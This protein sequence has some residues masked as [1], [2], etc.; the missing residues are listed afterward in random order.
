MT[1]PHDHTDNTIKLRKPADVLAAVPYLLGFHPTDSI[2]LVGLEGTYVRVVIRL[3]LPPSSADTPQIA[4]R[5]VR[6]LTANRMS[7]ALLIGY[8][9]GCQITPIMDGIST[10]MTGAGIEIMEMLR[11]QDGRYWSYTCHDPQC[12]PLDGTPYDQVS[13]EAAAVAVVSGLVAAADQ[14][15]FTKIV[16]PIDGPE[17]RIMREATDAAR[18]RATA[19][20]AAPTEYGWLV[21]GLR[22]FHLCCDH[23]E[24]GRKIPAQEIAW[25]GVLLTSIPIRDITFAVGSERGDDL[26]QR[27]WTDLTRRVEPEYVPGPAT[28]L[29]FLAV[30]SGNGPLARIAVNRALSADPTYRFAHLLMTALDIGVSPTMAADMDLSYLAQVIAEQAAKS[31]RST[32]PILPATS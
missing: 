7:R 3:D 25:M 21:E 28:N 24:A 20:L 14:E 22:Q 16:A 2:V 10:R 27:L 6:T 29:A 5:C 15:A 13:S 32:R 31:P 19:L 23:I 9:P 26:C 1:T 8:G 18:A 12:C 4:E 17:R 30:R 11:C